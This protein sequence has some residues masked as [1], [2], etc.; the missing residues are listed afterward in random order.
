MPSSALRGDEKSVSCP[1]RDLLGR[2]LTG[3]ARPEPFRQTCH[4]ARMGYVG[5]KQAQDA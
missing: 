1:A 2:S 5:A 4:K 3:V